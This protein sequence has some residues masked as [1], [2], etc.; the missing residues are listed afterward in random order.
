MKQVFLIELSDLGYDS[1]N[2]NAV[3]AF[4]EASTL[5]SDLLHGRTD[6]KGIEKKLHEM[7]GYLISHGRYY[8]DTTEGNAVITCYQK[9]NIP[10]IIE[11]LT[12]YFEL[13]KSGFD[14][15][16]GIEF[17]RHKGN[18]KRRADALG[19]DF[20]DKLLAAVMPAGVVA[21]PAVEQPL[22]VAVDQVAQAVEAPEV[23]FNNGENNNV[24]QF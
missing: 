6:E 11:I 8:Y 15:P 14:A 18:V 4:Q 7:S 13:R 9:E 22:N 3:M 1:S 2:P 23:Q 5:I 19:K 21:A 24:Q 16:I 12:M 10:Y 17:P 20:Q